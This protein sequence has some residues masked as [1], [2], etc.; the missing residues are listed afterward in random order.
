M[1]TDEIRARL[2]ELRETKASLEGQLE[3]VRRDLAEALREA[4]GDPAITIVEAAGLA[5][6]SRF[7]VYKALDR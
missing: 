4:D 6:L 7:S 5:G 3:R 2:V 1:K